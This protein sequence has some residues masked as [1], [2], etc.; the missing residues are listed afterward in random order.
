MRVFLTLALALALNAC[1]SLKPGCF[2]QEQAASVAADV[3]STQ[4]QCANYTAVKADLADAFKSLGLCKTQQT[5]PI[6]DAVCPM[7]VGKV[8]EFVTV[9]SIPEK[10]EC[11]ATNAQAKLASA[12]TSACKKI[13]VAACK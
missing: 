10:W 3:V 1:S 6:A 7:L 11:S 4:L 13:P 12:L 5:G 9:N 2:L 8:V